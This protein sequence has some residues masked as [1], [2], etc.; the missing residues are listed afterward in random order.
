MKKFIIS[1]IAIVTAICAYPQ[2]NVVKLHHS[3]GSVST[4][5]A[6]DI[7]KI[8]FEEETD[9]PSKVEAVDLGLSVKWASCN[10]GAARPEAF[11]DYYAW[12][13]TETKEVYNA[14]TYKFYNLEWGIVTKIGHDI[15]GTQ[16]DVAKR[17]MGDEWR[18]PTRDEW[19]ELLQSCTV[20]RVTINGVTGFRCTADNGNSIFLPSAG[21]LYDKEGQ[22]QNG[23]ENV[24]GFYWTSQVA[25]DD[26]Y[27][28]RIYRASL[29]PQLYGC[30]GYDVPEIG[31][32]VRAVQGEISTTDPEPEP[33]PM[34]MV[35]LGL[36]VK[37][38]SH[39]VGAAKASDAGNYYSWGMTKVQTLYGDYGY[40][41]YNADTDSYEDLGEDISGTKY[42]VATV[43]WGE[44]WRI[45]TK[46]EL[47]E[48]VEKC[49]WS[50]S[51]QDNKLGYKVTGPNGNYI[52]LPAGGMFGAE[53]LMQ[54]KPG[55][56]LGH[57]GY[58]TSSVQKPSSY[59][60]PHSRYCLKMR[61]D[62]YKV[63]DTFK[64]IG[65]LVR[66]VHN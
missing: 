14:T 41:Y 4:F 56:I 59:G 32:S 3:N 29:S 48:L 40:P 31:M 57:V 25:E 17:K 49:T 1:I 46:A 23:Y 11:G 24:S 51:S 28:Y 36:S 64:S 30:S 2:Q 7:S 50:W 19:V 53:G 6:N 47:E 10:V 18:M 44:G 15:A 26:Q 61:S 55:D 5:N 8:T 63:D 20:E 13:E 27:N 21:R 37:W 66:P 35:D 54:D 38:A 39:N 33:G 12:G 45:P 9:D 43:R 52:F 42:D 22:A 34:D 65:I 62:S 60:S 58:Y 16:Y